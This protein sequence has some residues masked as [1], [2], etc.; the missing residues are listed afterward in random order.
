MST[1]REELESFIADG[2]PSNEDANE[3][4]GRLLIELI[5]IEGKARRILQSRTVPNASGE[6]ESLL[7]LTLHEA[8]YRVLRDTGRPLHARE[9][10]SQIKRRG[11]NHPRSTSA[12]PDQIV[13]QLA[14]R[15][16][17]YPQFERVAPNTFGLSEWRG[18]LA[19]RPKPRTGLFR[20]PGGTT[21]R[22]TSDG[23][24]VVASEEALWRS[25]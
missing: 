21:A 25:S 23:E 22:S 13:Y 1:V 24:V 7:G 2:S 4:A 16:P 17:R 15:L 20:G 19:E 3:E 12:R 10:G 5:T 18:R 6:F 14:A 11:W 8:A 9:L